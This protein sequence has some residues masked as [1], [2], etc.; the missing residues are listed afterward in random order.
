[1][2]TVGVKGF[3][4]KKNIIYVRI[5]RLKLT[6]INHTVLLKTTCRLV[7]DITVVCIY[8]MDVITVYCDR[9]RSQR[10]DKGQCP[11]HFTCKIF[12]SVETCPK[13][14]H[15]HSKTSNFSQGRDYTTL[16]RT[17]IQWK[18]SSSAHPI[19]RPPQ[20][21]SAYAPDRKCCHFVLCN[22]FCTSCLPHVT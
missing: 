2:T 22:C 4:L 9:G 18:G 15:F 20:H 14:R 13:L 5:L 19:S 7:Y 21:N 8:A 17:P 1:M 12:V 6:V 3:I 16:L 11:R 10:D